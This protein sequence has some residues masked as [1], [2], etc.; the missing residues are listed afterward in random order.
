VVRVLQWNI[1]RGYKLEEIIAE[2]KRIDADVLALQEIDIGC[3][4]SNWEDTGERIAREL[5]LNYA[6]V[7]EFEEIYSSRRNDHSQGGGVHGN[8]ILSKFDMCDIEAIDH[9]Y[10]PVDWEDSSVAVTTWEPRRGRRLSLAATVVTPQG[11]LLV[12]SA[13]LEV[14]TGIVGRLEQFS[15]LLRHSKDKISRGYTHQALLGDLNTL[16]HGIVRWSPQHCNDSL[17]WRSLGHSEGQFWTD[18]VL[19]VYDPVYGK[20]SMASQPPLMPQKLVEGL[21]FSAESWADDRRGF[22][23][24]FSCACMGMN[25]PAKKVELMTGGLCYEPM[26]HAMKGTEADGEICYDR[27]VNKKLL[28]LGLSVEV[29]RD[30][31]NPGFEDPFDIHSPT[32]EPGFMKICG[33]PLM[34]GKLDWLLLRCADVVRKETGNDDYSMSDHKWLLADINLRQGIE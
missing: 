14:F 4:R 24:P 7:C 1:E 13:H 20:V 8:A 2:L 6:F 15:E 18:Y 19:Q 3:A 11:P 27:F 9:R 32:L 30:L 34:N 22:C 33:Y 25:S 17:R 28:E 29:C 12:Y 26:Q 23:V 31:L 5:G 21:P 10:Q 16:G